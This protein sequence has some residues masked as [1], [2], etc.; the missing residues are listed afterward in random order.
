MAGKFELKKSKNDKYFFNLLAGNG[1]RL[2]VL[3]VQDQ[4][5]KGFGAGDVGALAHIDE[6]RVLANKDGLQAR[7]AHGGH[8]RNSSSGDSSRH[9]LT[10]EKT[11]NRIEN[12]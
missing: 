1:Q 3:L 4:A 11:R 7:Q 8:G 10:C 6:Q 5:R 9:Q 2:F 12:R